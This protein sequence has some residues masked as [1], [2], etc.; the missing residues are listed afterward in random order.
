[1]PL[2]TPKARQLLSS[3]VVDSDLVIGGCVTCD[4]LPPPPA[5][6]PAPCLQAPAEGTAHQP[7]Q[8]P[9]SGWPPTS[10][11]TTSPPPRDWFR[12]MG[13]TRREGFGKEL[14]VGSIWRQASPPFPSLSSCLTLPPRPQTS[15]SNNVG[16]LPGVLSTSRRLKHVSRFYFVIRGELTQFGSGTACHRTIMLAA[17]YGSRI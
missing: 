16:F 4:P 17:A 6:G 3:Q 10:L 14:L 2:M 8:T 15:G 1:M 11:R 12:A 5:E 7:C 9:L 13:K